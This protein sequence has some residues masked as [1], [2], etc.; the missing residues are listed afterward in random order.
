MWPRA[1]QRKR[2]EWNQAASCAIRGTNIGCVSP[3]HHDISSTVRVA[4]MGIQQ[5]LNVLRKSHKFPST[6][7]P[8][9]V[10]FAQ[11]LSLV[12][13]TDEPTPST[14]KIGAHQ[15]PPGSLDPA[16]CRLLLLLLLEWPGETQGQGINSVS[17]N[18]YSKQKL[19]VK[20]PFT[21][22]S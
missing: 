20:F 3:S 1:T 13:K 7:S 14:M 5:K 6:P 21:K 19:N 22:T 4:T 11:F 8:T 12:T 17:N 15:P 9:S 10:S 18:I 16:S 2:K